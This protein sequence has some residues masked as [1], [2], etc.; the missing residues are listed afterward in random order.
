MGSS[1][2]QFER[3]WICQS[4]SHNTLHTYYVMPPSW[5]TT[6]NEICQVI[7]W[8]GYV[9]HSI[10]ISTIYTMQK[11]QYSRIK[12]FIDMYNVTLLILQ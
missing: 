8:P 1:A 7:Y 3:T 12:S 4:K 10:A 11:Y 9:Y 6:R 2:L 5:L